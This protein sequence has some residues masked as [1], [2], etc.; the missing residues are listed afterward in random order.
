MS[1]VGIGL[2]G[3]GAIAQFH[4]DAYASDP[5]ARVVAIADVNGE[6]AAEVAVQRGIPQS[7][8]GHAALL[9]APDVDAV[10][11]CTWNDSHA[12]IALAAIAAG[13]HV[14]CE[15]P[16]TITL[17][18]ALRVQVAAT[19]ATTVFEVGYVRRFAP[20]ALALKRFVDAGRL[21][22]IYAAEAHIL[23]RAGNPGGWFADVSRSGGG[24]LIDLGVHLI[25]LCWFFMG[26]PE[27]LTVSGNRYSVLGNRGNIETLDR[28]RAS[29]Y[30]VS[31]NSVEDYVNGL[32]RFEGGASMLLQTSYSL[33]ATEDSVRVVMYGDKGGAALEPELRIATEMEDIVMNLTPQMDD[34]SFDM[35]AAFAAEI[36][37][38]VDLC[39]G[40]GEPVAPVAHGVQ[41]ICIVRALYESAD[42]GHEID[43]RSGRRAA[44]MKR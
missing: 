38:F 37:H 32:I 43:L 24:P 18:D 8:D 2:I 19:E 14:L 36:R 11:I 27:P 15:K 33:H 4:L 35:D 26:T 7:F 25:D 30:D 29:D 12:E 21:G 22:R 5:R 9:A 1:T 44:Q 28:Y 20:N 16:L 40:A 3:A 39:L 6:R 10:S 23:R 41:M 17:E 42:I 34:P 13:K 31:R